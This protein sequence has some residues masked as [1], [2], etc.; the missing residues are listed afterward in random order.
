MDDT[1]RFR[2]RFGPYS[3]PLF[4]IGDV[5][6]CSARGQVTIVGITRGK[7]AWPIGKTKR[8]KSLVLFGD[9]ERAVRNEAA[10]A[11]CHWWGVGMLA[12]NKWRHA[13]GIAGTTNAGTSE[14]RRLHFAEPWGEA[15]RKKAWSKLSDPKRRAK[16][17]ESMRGKA[18]PPHVIESMRQARIGK[19]HTEDTKRK[20]REARKRRAQL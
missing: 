18:R 13:L 14:L 10:Q 20:M 9:L 16:I 15:T 1:E 8:A 3:T 11:I 6:T 12:V 2:L 19:S 5:V 7:I 4:E 17:A